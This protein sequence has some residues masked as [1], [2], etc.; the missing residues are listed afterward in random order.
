[1]ASCS[2]AHSGVQWHDL[3]SPQPSPPGL[4]RFFCLSLP[5]SWDYRHVP[6]R[7]ANLCV[8]LVETEFHHVG[9]PG[10][11]LLTSGDPLALTSQSAGITDMNHRAQPSL[12]LSAC[13]SCS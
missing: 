2:V 6:P 13:S 3:D 10:L 7:L 4:K 12:S 8:F 11:E 1:M 9:Q 5:S